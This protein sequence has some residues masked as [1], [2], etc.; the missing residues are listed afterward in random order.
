MR[1]NITTNGDPRGWKNRINGAKHGTMIR[2]SKNGWIN[3]EL[4][5][6]HTDGCVRF[7][8][9]QKLDDGRPHLLVLDQHYSNLYN[10]EFLQLMKANNIHI[11]ALPSHTSHWLQPL[12]R[13]VFNS[14]KAA[15]RDEMRLFT[16]E[17]AG[18]KLEK[19]DFFHVFN[20]EWD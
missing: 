15:W 1:P 10:R 3:K 8:H 18:R 20:K 14:F 17:T 2:A 7:I 9:A 16:R 6:E 19:K 5:T 12:D 11:L 13:G 4:F